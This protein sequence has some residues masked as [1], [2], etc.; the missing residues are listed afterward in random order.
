[1]MHTT[2]DS[3]TEKKRP[4]G[5]STMP[6]RSRRPVLVTAVSALAV[7]AVIGGFAMTPGHGTPI[8]EAKP[9]PQATPTPAGKP[10]APPSPRPKSP[11]PAEPT[12]EAAKEPLRSN[13]EEPEAP[14]PTTGPIQ[15]E[16]TEVERASKTADVVVKSM[17]QIAKRGDGK[18]AG[19]DRLATGF[20]LGEL[21]AQAQEQ[22]DLGLRQI[23]EA[24]VTSVKATAV[25]LKSPKPSMTLTV[26]IDVSKVDV[27]NTAGQ[28]LKKSLYNPGRPVK[29]IYGAEFIDN[30]WKI[31]THDIPDTQDCGATS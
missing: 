4:G 3:E 25:K 19:I 12:D 31:A 11:A 8:A 9:V 21:Q 5:N 20:V 7:T 17:N 23:G 15:T 27:V 24:R 22:K 28:S 26:C 1:M 2:N 6:S 10:S 29:H 16:K 30:V 14:P 13:A 18:A